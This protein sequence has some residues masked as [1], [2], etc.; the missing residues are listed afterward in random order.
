MLPL[1]YFTEWINLAMIQP[2]FSS[3]WFPG[4]NK[5]GHVTCTTHE[6]W[7]LDHL[8]SDRQRNESFEEGPIKETGISVVLSATE[9]AD[10]FK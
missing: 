4:S 10:M 9:N 2:S 6:H 1:I 3:L 5:R 7:H 8:P